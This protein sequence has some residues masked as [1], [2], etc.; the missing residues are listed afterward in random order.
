ML[1]LIILFLS[2]FITYYFHLYSQLNNRKSN[3]YG[4][5]S[6]WGK[7][8]GIFMLSY[9]LKFRTGGKIKERETRGEGIK[10]I[11]GEIKWKEQQ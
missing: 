10:L 1:G 7:H 2:P 5:S 6:H 11:K 8:T 9:G 4:N 3:F